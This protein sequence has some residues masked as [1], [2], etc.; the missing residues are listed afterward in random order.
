MDLF[1][2]RTSESEKGFGWGVLLALL[3]LG[4][5][6]S[7][8][9][10]TYRWHVAETHRWTELPSPRGDG[11]GFQSLD[12]TAT[13]VGFVNSVGE[14]HV[15]QNQHLLNGSGVA[16]GDVNGDGWPDLYLARLAGPNALYLNLGPEAEGIRFE[17]VPEAGGAPLPG[18]YSTG[19][20]LADVTGDGWLDLLVTTLGGPNVLYENEG[21]GSFRQVEAAG[22]HAGRGSTTM[23]LADM[24]GDRALDLYV[25][26]YKRRAM[27]D[28]LPPDELGFENIVEKLGPREY[29]VASKF[30][31]EYE[32]RTIGDKVFHFEQAE[33]DRVYFNDGTGRFEEQPWR[34]V[35][36]EASGEPSS[37]VPEFWGLV[38]RL[39]DLN[40]DGTPD[41]Y[42]CNDFESPDLFYGGVQGAGRFREMPEQTVRTTSHST[43]SI[44]TT[45]LE[46]D[47]DVDFF[48][49]D[50]LGVGYERRQQQVGT[51]APIPRQVGVTHSRMQEMQNTLQMDRGDGTYAEVSQLAG[52]E[53]SGWTWSS[54]FVDVNLDGFD[55]LL[56]STGHA[57]DIQSADAQTKANVLKKRATT[58][59]EFRRIIFRYP[60]LDLE[61]EAFRN[62]GDGTFGRVEN[63]WGLGA[64]PDVGHGM[65]TGDFDRDGDLDVVINRLNRTVGIYRNEATAP[66]VA[67]RLAGRAPNTGGIGATIRVEPIGGTVPAQEEA[68]I[69]G[70][71]YVSDSGG[72]HVFAAGAADSVQIEVRWPEGGE[73]VVG[74]GAGR[75]YEIRQSGA[76]PGWKGAAASD[77]L[78]AVR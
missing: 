3:V 59:E 45:D 10:H 53:A 70:G 18:E 36:R 21:D 5:C 15:A 6:G 30:R 33:P 43:M 35:F 14:P 62:E 67:V 2:S 57:F 20:V 65:A 24:N 37:K 77:S 66:R 11:P 60:R 69:A 41:L 31:D 74:G 17:K 78:R 61:N 29:E 9:D 28:S 58:Y 23:A 22:L 42:V 40:G 25:T 12:S 34:E 39:E 7:Q 16:I 46:R 8:Y 72:T 48:L 63:G 27:R 54:T 26:N 64:T 56:L 44:A 32:V 68:V 73:T 1:R 76:T 47:G 19:A 38:A 50:M 71:E 75:L 52:V 4:G 55:D 49:A 51:R 13:G